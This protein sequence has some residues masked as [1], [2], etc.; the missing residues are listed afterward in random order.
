MDALILGQPGIH[1][2]VSISCTSHWIKEQSTQDRTLIF[3]FYFNKF[4]LSCTIAVLSCSEIGLCNSYIEDTLYSLFMFPEVTHCHSVTYIKLD[5]TV[6]DQVLQQGHLLV[7]HTAFRIVLFSC[8]SGDYWVMMSL[9]LWACVVVLSP[10]IVLVR[11]H[12]AASQHPTQLTMSVPL[13]R[14]P[15]LWLFYIMSSCGA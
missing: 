7:E 10:V 9:Y 6:Q 5:F 4:P 1:I 11:S 14:R 3:F 15:A 12:M 13:L 8:P 2:S